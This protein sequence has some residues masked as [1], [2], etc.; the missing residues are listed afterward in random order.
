MSSIDIRR[1]LHSKVCP[2]ISWKQAYENI[3]VDPELD[4]LQNYSVYRYAS[5][6]EALALC[7]GIIT[8]SSPLSW[9]DKYESLV[10][11]NLFSVGA[12]FSKAVPYV[13]CF[14][15]EYSSEAM[16]RVYS[17]AGGLA[18]VGLKLPSLLEGL[19]QSTWPSKGKV[20][21]GRVRYMDAP[22]L[23]SEV[24]AI[25]TRTPKPKATMNNAMPALL[26]KRAGFS[27][28]NEIRVAFLPPTSSELGQNASVREFPTNRITKILLDPYLPK[29][30]TD[31]IRSLFVDHLKVP[32]GV[33]RSAF[34]DS[35][36]QTSR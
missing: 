24:D 25:A 12:P 14:S 3:Y 33:Y 21:V 10:L 15:V 26:M 31:E 18:R 5:I 30:Q 8:L 4:V 17:G 22:Q 36:D 27:F 23:R 6:A 9:P 32:F 28:E 34:D 1:H 20:Y 11:G 2:R 19:S 16:W 35:P 13:K 7:R 29:W